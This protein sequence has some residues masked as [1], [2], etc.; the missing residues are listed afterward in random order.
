M[1]YF[2]GKAT[3]FSFNLGFKFEV[4]AREPH[5]SALKL[6]TELNINLI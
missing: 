6:Q 4:R 3:T 2:L 5:G 1:T